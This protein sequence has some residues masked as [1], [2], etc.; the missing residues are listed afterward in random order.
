VTVAAPLGF[1]LDALSAAAFAAALV[2]PLADAALKG[3]LVLAGAY[4]LTRWGMRHAAAATRH[5]VWTAAVGAVLALPVLALV[6]PRWT[7][8]VVPAVAAERA[9]RVLAAAGPAAAPPRRWC[10]RSLP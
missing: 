3:A 7:L 4:A 2:P 10:R 9:G 5:L 8:S 1:G 6:A